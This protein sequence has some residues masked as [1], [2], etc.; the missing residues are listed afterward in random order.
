M[1]V[2]LFQRNVL[3]AASMCPNLA[4]ANAEVTGSR[5]VILYGKVCNGCSQSYAKTE[6]ILYWDNG[7]KLIILD[8]MTAYKIIIGATPTVKAWKYRKTVWTWAVGC[9]KTWATHANAYEE[10]KLNKTCCLNRNLILEGTYII[11]DESVNWTISILPV[12][13]FHNQIQQLFLPTLYLQMSFIS[14]TMFYSKPHYLWHTCQH[15]RW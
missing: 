15:V 9:H 14:T 2:P 11:L 10:K 1:P 7:N 4:L 8:G 6:S 3:P 12:H 13:I 5:S